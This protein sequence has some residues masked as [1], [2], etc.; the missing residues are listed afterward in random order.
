MRRRLLE[1]WLD[2]TD[3]ALLARTCWKCGEAALS[4]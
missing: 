4:S 3:I 2:P 1:K